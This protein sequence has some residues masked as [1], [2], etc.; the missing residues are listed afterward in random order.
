MGLKQEIV[1]VSCDSSSAIQ[2][3]KNPKDHERTKHI[4]VKMHFIRDEISKGV[5]NVVKVPTE[6]NPSDMLTKPL[7][8]VRFRKLLSLIGFVSL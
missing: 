1:R 4:D 3:S 8:L 5:V 7:P 2:L 6:V